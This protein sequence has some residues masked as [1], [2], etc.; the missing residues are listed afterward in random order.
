MP[1]TDPPTC[2]N[3][4]CIAQ[5]LFFLVS[6]E[7]ALFS[8]TCI[9]IRIR[10]GLEQSLIFYRDLLGFQEVRRIFNGAATAL[11]GGCTHHELFLIQVGYAP[12]P[13]AVRYPGL[14]HIG[15]KNGPTREGIERRAY[16]L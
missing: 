2:A 14:Y 13:P 4:Q 10:V 7:A 15:I 8:G 6:D 9:P 3:P 1:Q 16:E 11:T 12:G 5:T